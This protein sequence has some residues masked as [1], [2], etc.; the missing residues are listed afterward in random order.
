M[1]K[2][3]EILGSQLTLNIILSIFVVVKV[4]L[5]ITKK[6][7]QKKGLEIASNVVD[8]V[9][10]LFE[11]S[12]NETKRERAIVLLQEE[13]LKYTPASLKWLVNLTINPALLTWILSKFY[14]E[15]AVIEKETQ[16]AVNKIAD[17]VVE[18]VA[19]KEETEK[20]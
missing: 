7:V 12:S 5:G 17:K 2:F 15:K 9:A 13:I 1:E 6:F 10:D 4:V 8:R 14:S 11:N 18:K 20:K 3:L 19:E 16:K